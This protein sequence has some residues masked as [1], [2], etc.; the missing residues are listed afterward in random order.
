MRP[1][2][3]LTGSG[4]ALLAVSRYRPRRRSLSHD[5][6]E[7]PRRRCKKLYTWRR[8]AHEDGTR[9]DHCSTRAGCTTRNY[10]E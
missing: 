7:R 6:Q 8:A 5:R 4:R 2:W 1:S 9:R 10:Y 3:T